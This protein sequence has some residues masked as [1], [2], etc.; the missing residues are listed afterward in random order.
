MSDTPR[1][2]Q[3]PRAGDHRCRSGSKDG[4]PTVTYKSAYTNSP[5]SD[6][7]AAQLLS[8]LEGA[9]PTIVLFFAAL[10]HDG[11]LLGAALSQALPNTR[12]IGCSSNGTFSQ[13]DH[14]EGGASAIA[15]G[16]ESVARAAVAV[17]DYSGGIESGVNEACRSLENQLGQ[18][19]NTLAHDRFVAL[20]LVEGGTRTEEDFA[21]FLGNRAPQLAVVGGS[22]GDNAA[23]EQTWVVNGATAAVRASVIAILELKVPFQVV[24]ENHFSCCDQSMVVTRADPSRRLV[25]EFDG[26]PAAE[27]FAKRL[28]VRPQELTLEA[29]THAPLGAL[30]NGSPWIRAPIR[31]EGSAIMFACAMPEKAHVSFVRPV[32]EGLIANTRFVLEKTQRDLGSGLGAAI[33]FDCTGRKLEA[34][35]LGQLDEYRQVFEH[36]EHA[37]FFTNGETFLGHIN[38]TLTGLFLGHP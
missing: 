5:D 30:V 10:H 31:R 18:R 14:G 3:R 7:A 29:L 12:I 38:L 23:F 4:Y 20:V 16:K 34:A 13:D 19:L 11:G 37:G 9:D 27:L 21:E 1:P 33:L 32:E 26:V 15:L 28:G 8:Q 25:Y 35:G 24:Q 6:Q 36:F 17:A 2:E 22:A